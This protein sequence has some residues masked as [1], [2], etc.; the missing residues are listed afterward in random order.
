MGVS[1]FWLYRFLGIG[2]IDGIGGIPCGMGG[3]TTDVTCS[4]IIGGRVSDESFSV[5]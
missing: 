2:G 3:G 5:G 4:G 1:W